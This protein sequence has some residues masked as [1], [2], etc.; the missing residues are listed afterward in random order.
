MNELVKINNADIRVK[1][2]RGQRIVTMWDIAKAH[3]IS[4]KVIR[5]NFEHNVNFMSKGKHY[6]ILSKNDSF[7]YDLIESG[8]ISQNQLNAVKDIPLFTEKGYLMIV[9]PLQGE[10]AWR[11]QE[12]MID[13]YFNVI[14][15]ITK[16]SPQL[17]LLINMELE[18]KRLRDEILETA[19]QTAAVK[20]EVND[21]REVIGVNMGDDWRK[22]TNTLLAKICMKIKDYQKPKDTVYKI[23]EERAHCQLSIRLANL[24]VRALNNGMAPSKV[25]KLNY[26]D[27][28]E[29]DVR[30]KEIYIAIVKEIAIRNG[31]KAS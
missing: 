16:L 23:L 19:K 2:F 3:D 10:L 5:E 22:H 24:K 27:A 21:I 14:E 20:E 18:Q 7:A 26:L 9:K 25:N 1:E 4:A 15:A 17:Q 28:I 11:V 13:K 12:E 30:L 31:I 8:E 6:F 29:D